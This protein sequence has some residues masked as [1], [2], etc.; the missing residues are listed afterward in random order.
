MAPKA[1]TMP[2]CSRLR[3]GTF[4]PA[5]LEAARARNDLTATAPPWREALVTP[6]SQRSICCRKLCTSRVKQK[7]LRKYFPPWEDADGRRRRH[8]PPAAG[9]ADRGF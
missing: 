1:K 3:V 8:K 4:R 2:A 7:C 5:A 9:D 6:R